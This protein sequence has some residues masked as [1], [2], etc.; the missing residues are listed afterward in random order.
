MNKKS[1]LV[2]LS[3]FIFLS[4]SIYSQSFLDTQGF[5]F[6]AN[7]QYQFEPGELS[8]FQAGN[9]DIGL[10]AY[11]YV[12]VK[13]PFW[14]ESWGPS[15]HAEFGWPLALPDYLQHWFLMNFTAGIW[16]DIRVLPVL[17]IRPELEIGTSV[18]FI[19]SRERDLK[20]NYADFFM[21]IGA[22]A[23]FEPNFMKEND[24][25]FTGG[26]NFSF[27]PENDHFV[28]NIGL[29]LGVIWRFGNPVISEKEPKKEVAEEVK[30]VETISEEQRREE[31]QAAYEKA[32]AEK[33]EEEKRRAEEE[34]IRLAQEEAIKEQEQEET[35]EEEVQPAEPEPVVVEAATISFNED[36][37]VN[38]AIPTLTFIPN[39][40]DLQD[41][42]KNHEALQSVFK[43]M[44]D[45]K[46]SEFRCIVTG[47][48]NA[49]SEIWT[50]EE[51]EFAIG[52]AQKVIDRL[53]QLGISEERFEAKYGSGKTADKVY[54]RRVEFKLVK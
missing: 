31:A 29:C 35:S 8:K 3:I 34:K 13:A 52:R 14:F 53:V 50:D 27:Q 12:P 51:N 37:S 41:T 45:E 26:L 11:Y 28:T 10:E 23:I 49:D 30:P 22:N 1:L 6:G 38:I 16:G 47:Y 4:S 48:I 19:Q 9:I 33:I 39:S 20:S 40:T 15:I 43:I 21:R 44:S 36:G 7:L 25:A 32:I 17:R 2:F 42:E 46:Y 18:N 5:D 24:L 54:N